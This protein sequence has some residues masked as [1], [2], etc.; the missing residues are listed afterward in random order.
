[1]RI[2]IRNVLGVKEAEFKTDSES[3]TLIAGA[4]GSGKSSVLKAIGAT[5]QMNTNPLGVPATARNA[6]RYGSST[7][8]YCILEGMNGTTKWGLPDKVHS[9]GNRPY[10][11][12]W[13]VGMVNPLDAKR[14]NDRVDMWQK[15]INMAMTSEK[16]RQLFHDVDF[17]TREQKTCVVDDVIQ[18]GWDSAQGAQRERGRQLK[19]LWESAVAST[20]EKVTYGT[21]VASNWKPSTWLDSYRGMS[22]EQTSEQLADAVA[23]LESLKEVKTINA[24]DKERLDKAKTSVSVIEKKIKDREEIRDAYEDTLEVVKAKLKVLQ[25]RDNLNSEC[26]VQWS[27]DY[28]M[29][30]HKVS[31]TKDELQRDEARLSEYLSGIETYKD[32]VENLTETRGRIEQEITA[33]RVELD[34][35][36]ETETEQME[37]VINC[38]SCRSPL[39]FDGEGKLILA[40]VGYSQLVKDK[41]KEIEYAEQ[42]KLANVCK[43]LQN[44]TG[45]KAS[46]EAGIDPKKKD[47]EEHRQRLISLGSAKPPEP[48]VKLPE[49][50]EMEAEVAHQKQVIANCDSEITDL[51]GQHKQMMAFIEEYD[52]KS[53]IDEEAIADAQ[54]GATEAKECHDA[55]EAYEVAKKMHEGVIAS[56]RILALLAPTGLRL[57]HRKASLDPV[58]ENIH[59]LSKYAGWGVTELNP[60]TL[61]VSFEGRDVRFCSTSEQMRA[62]IVLRAAVACVDDSEMLLID[63]IEIFDSMRLE[64]LANMLAYMRERLTA[65][66]RVILAGTT[67][68]DI[69][70]FNKKYTINTC[71]MM[72]HGEMLDAS[73]WGSDEAS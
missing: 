54:R 37:Q 58:L 12:E 62:S 40:N 17:M 39:K 51:E 59:Q 16:V 52:G 45:M 34:M 18:G 55:V 9:Q 26:Y 47:I 10:A 57:S 46:Y 23:Q 20:G 56:D 41:K 3:P 2:E 53:L 15:A 4:N 50:T 63:D 70:K 22:R 32:R 24:S 69:I 19:R 33:M 7:E 8:G 44:A 71:Q 64:A 21:R 30:M 72:A 68:E 60:E 29:H 42:D 36:K 66:C 49:L 14:S 38:P 48:Y 25:D 43:S 1:M 61:E 31:V 13:A 11:S 65:R 6:Y 28:D 35:L 67:T 27:H 73:D 5:L